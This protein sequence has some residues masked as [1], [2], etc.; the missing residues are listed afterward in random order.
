GETQV[1]AY[2]AEGMENTFPT[3]TP[4]TTAIFRGRG[5]QPLVDTPPVLSLNP[6]HNAKMVAERSRDTIDFLSP[7]IGPFPYSSLL[8][9][10]MPGP[11]SQGWPGLI[12]LS[13]HVF[14]K[15]EQR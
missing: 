9:T 4:A 15:P 14:L 12:Y 3:G 7:R 6:A 8:I 13:S 10:Q 1:M 5:R 11:D 2:A